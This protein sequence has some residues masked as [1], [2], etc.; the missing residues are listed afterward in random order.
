[1]TFAEKWQAA[2]QTVCREYAA[3]PPAVGSRV[4]ELTDAIASAKEEMHK[5]AAAVDAG[6]ACRTCGGACCA[7]GRNH[8]TVVDLLTFLG[9][10]R[11]LFVPDFGAPLCPYLGKGGCLMEPAFRPF[12]CMIFLCEEIDSLLPEPAREQLTRL[13]QELR[14]LYGELE[15]LFRTRF[16]N[17]LFI[18]YERALATGDGTLLNIKHQGAQ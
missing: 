15:R 13:E 17:G 8:F 18:S 5:V 10:D 14:R 4:G 9:R 6:G 16:A 3:L 1:M 11:A 12:N 2:V 7:H